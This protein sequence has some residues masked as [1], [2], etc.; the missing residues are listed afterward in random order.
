MQQD[1]LGLP[2]ALTS[3]NSPPPQYQTLHRCEKV[4]KNLCFMRIIINESYPHPHTFIKSFATGFAKLQHIPATSHATDAIK[5][6]TQS[7]YVVAY[8]VTTMPIAVAAKQ[9]MK[10][11]KKSVASAYPFSTGRFISAGMLLASVFNALA[12][13]GYACAA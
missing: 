11:F 6:C 3:L 13:C 1:K 8:Q 10:P 4:R 5:A 7:P 12:I 9:I 2:K